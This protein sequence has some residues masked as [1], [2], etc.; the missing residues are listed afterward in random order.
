MFGL[1]GSFKAEP[2]RRDEL[3]KLMLEGSADMPGC[4]S[5]VV[6]ADV[7]DAD[8]IWV[9]E[10]WTDKAAHEASLQLPE[11]QAVIGKARPLIAGFGMHVSTAPAGGVGL[12]A[13]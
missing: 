6:A 3:V 12:K 5:Y 2:G 10:V 4:L 9:T 13:G 7:L 1:I 8:T 11:V